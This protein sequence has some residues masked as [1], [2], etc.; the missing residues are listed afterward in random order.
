MSARHHTSKQLQKLAKDLIELETSYQVMEIVS[1]DS[2]TG[3]VKI[4]CQTGFGNTV[5]ISAVFRDGKARLE[6][7]GMGTLLIKKM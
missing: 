1:S 7:P 3:T 4:K 5:D 2:K 6:A